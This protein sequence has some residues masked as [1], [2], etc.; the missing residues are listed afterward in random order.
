MA[1]FS[2]AQGQLSSNFVRIVAPGAPGELRAVAQGDGYSAVNTITIGADG[3][4]Q[5]IVFQEYDL[6]D[7]EKLVKNGLENLWRID[8]YGYLLLPRYNSKDSLLGYVLF[9]G[10]EYKEISF[11]GP[12]F[13]TDSLLAH[14]KEKYS[15]DSLFAQDLTAATEFTLKDGRTGIAFSSFGGG[16][17]YSVDGGANWKFVVNQ[18]GVKGNLGSIRVVPSVLRGEGA[19]ALVA[20]KVSQNSK[21]TIEVFSYDM[22]KIRTVV[23]DAPREGNP[24]RSSHRTEDTWDGKDK[25]GKSVAA[26]VYYIKVTDNHGHTG[27]GKAMVLGG[28]R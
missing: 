13:K 9:D 4:T 24:I 18:A 27:W 1:V 6:R 22:K 25:H 10:K 23:K 17:A 21:I 3:E 5:G 15:V 19:T 26:G 16:L 14:Y 20:Y 11:I 12:F 7:G 2:F 28:N 8:N